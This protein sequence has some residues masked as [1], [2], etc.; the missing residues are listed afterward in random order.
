MNP[1][2]RKKDPNR[3]REGNIYQ[4]QCG[5]RWK[6]QNNSFFGVHTMHFLW[7]ATPEIVPGYKDRGDAKLALRLNGKQCVFILE[8][9][10]NR[11]PGPHFRF[12]KELLEERCLIEGRPILV[13]HQP[14]E[15]GYFYWRVFN[16]EEIKQLLKE[17]KNR[18]RKNEGLKSPF[19]GRPY[20]VLSFSKW[21]DWIDMHN[22]SLYNKYKAE[23]H[24]KKIYEYEC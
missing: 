20:I 14:K 17:Y 19:Q 21:N 1:E 4:N 23:K 8:I 18:F 10:A 24:L 9:E 22:F 16:R 6:K 11:F 3:I 12:K 7:K 15:E 5:V 13:V 2:S